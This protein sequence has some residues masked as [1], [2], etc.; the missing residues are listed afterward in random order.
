[1]EKKFQAQF[2]ENEYNIAFQMMIGKLCVDTTEY[3]DMFIYY[4]LFLILQ[5]G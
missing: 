1:M 2:S 4:Y 5:M 3:V